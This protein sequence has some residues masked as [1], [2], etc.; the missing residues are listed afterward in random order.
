MECVP[1]FRDVWVRCVGVP[2][3]AWNAVMFERIAK[4][5]GSLLELEDISK[6][7][8]SFEFCRLRVRTSVVSRL[9]RKIDVLIDGKEFSIGVWEEWEDV[10]GLKGGQGAETG[11]TWVSDT[12]ESLPENV[13]AW[14]SGSLE[15]EWRS[16]V[17][18]EEGGGG[19][20]GRCYY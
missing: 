13:A 1:S 7:R 5:V 20:R 12:S 6:A 9:D 4:K 14:I 10:A 15:K 17:G 11:K 16:E 19:E 3:C 18:E 2:L 8:P